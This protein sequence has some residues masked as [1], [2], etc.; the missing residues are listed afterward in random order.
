MKKNIFKRFL[1]ITVIAASLLFA[2]N[3]SAISNGKSVVSPYWQSEGGVYTFVVVSH[4]SL[5]GM[6][7]RIGVNMQALDSSGAVSTST[8]F[9]VSNNAS[10]KL[11]IVPSTSFGTQFAV[12]TTTNSEATFLITNTTNSTVGNLR[13]TAVATNAGLNNCEPNTQRSLHCELYDITALS[14]WGAIVVLNTATGFAMEFVGDQA[15]SRTFDP[16]GNFSGIN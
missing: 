16:T 12:N 2:G 4:P 1:A 10:Q 7:T 5:S 13:F 11:F 15:D 8:T 14:Y 9:T 6:S 3:A